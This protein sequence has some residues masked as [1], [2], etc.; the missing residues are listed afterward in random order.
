MYFIQPLI[1]QNSGSQ[2]KGQ[3]ASESFYKLILLVLVGMTRYAQSTQ[4]S[5]FAIAWEFS[6]MKNEFDFLREDKHQYFIQVELVGFG[7]HNQSFP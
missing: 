3:N 6:R 1:W 5:K 2:V 4:N 7:G